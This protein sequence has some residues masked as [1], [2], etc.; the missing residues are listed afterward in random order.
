MN[1]IIFF[2]ISLG[3]A[4]LYFITNSISNTDVI[5]DQILIIKNII[6][7]C[8]ELLV[9]L[10][11]ILGIYNYPNI[12][13]SIKENFYK[14]II[15]NIN[16]S[17]N[18]T[19]LLCNDLIDKYLDLYY[20]NNRMSNQEVSDVINDINLFNR[21]AINSSSEIAYLSFLLKSTLQNLNR[22]YAPEKQQSYITSND[23]YTFVI[24]ILEEIM[25]YS[26]NFIY[27]PNKL[28]TK[29][30]SITNKKLSKYVPKSQYNILEPKVQEVEFNPSSYIHTL[31]Y[32]ITLKSNHPLFADSIIRC[33]V[34]FTTYRTFTFIE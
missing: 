3:P 24:N 26:E 32:S 20:T 22:L 2:L 11:I 34:F 4:I 23:F 5:L 13:R 19:K 27:I 29:K 12:M 17:N 1:K 16:K 21:S 28:K 10:S 15:W 25:F 31:F 18:E 8:K 7:F 30:I 9:I 6:I 14:D 33:Q